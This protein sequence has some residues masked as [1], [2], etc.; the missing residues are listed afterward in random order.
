MEKLLL[1]ITFLATS[2]SFAQSYLCIA[3]QAAYIDHVFGNDDRADIKAAVGTTSETK[4]IASE[5]GIFLFGAETPFFSNC[6]PGVS[7]TI[8][9]CGDLVNLQYFRVWANNLF[10]THFI[11][12]GDEVEEG[13]GR[14]VTIAGRCSKI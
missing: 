8:L 13:Y 7:G 6:A 2:P 4:F 3:E 11:T 1:V 9:E 14:S 12:S 10:L 5:K